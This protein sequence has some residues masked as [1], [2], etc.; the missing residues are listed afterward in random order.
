MQNL[1]KLIK[2]KLTPKSQ[3]TILL[4]ACRNGNPHAVRAALRAGANPNQPTYLGDYSFSA[5]MYEPLLVGS[6]HVSP[7]LLA[8]TSA[9][10][11]DER[12]YY[13]VIQLLAKNPKTNLNQV[14]SGHRK[15]WQ[16]EHHYRDAIPPFC[17]EDYHLSLHQ[18]V[19]QPYHRTRFSHAIEPSN[20]Y[21][22][23]PKMFMIL[24]GIS[25]DYDEKL[26]QAQTIMHGNIRS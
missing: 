8:A 4:N 20:L 21:P 26:R 18:V 14:V 10:G 6:V 19:N 22:M 9:L 24:Q 23:S 3:D 16:S 11:K 2:D 15:R 12:P 1:F 17:E 7:L 25:M 5:W 13:Q